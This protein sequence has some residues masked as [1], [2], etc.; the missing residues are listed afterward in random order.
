[1]R[2][3]AVRVAVLMG[4]ISPEHPVSLASGCGVLAHAD[5][6]RYEVFPVLISRAGVWIWP[7]D[8]ADFPA[9]M[10]AEQAQA[11]LASPPAG[12]RK[13]PF[14]DMPR[15]P[16]PHADIFFIALHGVGGEDGTLQAVLE[17]NGIAFTGSGGKASALSMD[18][19]ASKERYRAHGV[20][21]ASWIVL[22]PAE[23]ADAARVAKSADAV[24]RDVGLPAVVKDPMGGSS[25]GVAVVKTR[26]ELEDA[27]RGIGATAT[28]LLVEAFVTGREATCGVLE[29]SPKPLPP[30][31]IRPKKDGF[32]SF[33]EKYRK[34]GAEE[35]TP[36]E[37][38]P[39]VNAK[40]QRLAQLAH[41]ALGLSVYSRTDFIWNPSDDSL[42]A[43]ETNNLPGLT[44]KS[45][46]PQQAA[47]IGISYREL[48][49]RVIE[50][51]LR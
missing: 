16:F 35:I 19:I 42:C 2:R 20:P 23:Y 33:E 31:E 6:A 17:A 51:S 49:T 26:A 12:W 3:V 30:T 4:G 36:A 8:P 25:I 39:E 43:L 28:R 13:T 27:I 37:F 50:K 5:P 18:K 45:I 41:E 44:P 15:V 38:P 22:S 34:D 24:E 7:E 40:M 14:N 47:A 1:M 10:T 48:V 21:T 32:F 9:G 46:I 29:G 11:L